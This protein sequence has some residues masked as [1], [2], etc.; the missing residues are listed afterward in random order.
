VD[1]G[2]EPEMVTESFCTNIVSLHCIKCG[3]LN[4]ESSQSLSRSKREL[5]WKPVDLTQA[6]EGQ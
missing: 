6:K 5:G 1:C 4:E 3:Q 2:S